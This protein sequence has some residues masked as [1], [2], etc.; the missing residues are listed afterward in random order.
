M[1]EE[2]DIDSV[3]RNFINKW[4]QC[5]SA[6]DNDVNKAYL[7][8]PPP[9]D[10]QIGYDQYEPREYGNEYNRNN[11]DDDGDD[12]Y[13]CYGSIIIGVLFVIMIISLIVFLTKNVKQK[14]NRT[15][16]YRVVAVDSDDIELSDIGSSDQDELI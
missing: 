2:V 6:D 10:D 14:V 16:K 13:Y 8:P 5:Q 7:P 3:W 12:Y 4:K 11:Y 1:D 9:D 15:K